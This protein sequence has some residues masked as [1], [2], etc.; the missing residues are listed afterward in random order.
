MRWRALLADDV[1]LLAGT[2]WLFSREQFDGRVHTMFV[3]EAGQVSLADA[4]AIGT[5]AERLVLLG[6]PNQLAQV[7]QGAQ[8]DEV[9]R[10]V[11][12]HLLGDAITVPPDRGLFLEQTWRLRPE[13][14]AFTSEAYYEGRLDW[15]P[16][17]AVRS[18]EGEN[19]PAVLE[20][21]HE[22]C[23]QMSWPEAEAVAAE[24]QRLLGTPATDENGL[25]T[26]LAESDI[27][28]V[29]PYNAQVRALRAKLPAGVRV[30]TVDKFQGQQARVVLV[31]MA[32]SSAEDAPRGIEF[33]F[34]RHRVNVATSRAQCRVVLACA[35]RLLDADCKT[36]EQM[37]LVSALSRFVELAK[38]GIA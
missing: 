33:A 36:I 16:P 30:G 28:V 24:I 37:R 10:S 20:V 3:D 23:T 25:V 13:L 26:P 11:L 15:A 35:P 7:S 31:S 32:S 6:D 5:A 12:Q 22:G 2:S 29:A 38:P 17:C 1:Q 14:C 19:G 9:R 8:P 18:I 21:E 27:L 34:D 4:I